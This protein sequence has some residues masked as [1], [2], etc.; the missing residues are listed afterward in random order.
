MIL[1]NFIY[2]RPL[3]H[4]DRSVCLKIIFS[5]NSTKTYV[6][7]TQK[8]HLN[9]TILLSTLNI[10]Y[11]LWIR[12][13]QHFY[14]YQDIFFLDIDLCILLIVVFFSLAVHSKEDFSFVQSKQ[15]LSFTDFSVPSAFLKKLKHIAKSIFEMDN[16]SS[17]HMSN[18]SQ[19]LALRPNKKK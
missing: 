12:K 1:T 10:C 18:A 5:Y 8:S 11:N 4:V 3:D 9:E 13:Y 16:I 14:A 6:V 7:G 19:F 17:K 2:I 15:D